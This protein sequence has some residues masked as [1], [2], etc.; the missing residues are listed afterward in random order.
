VTIRDDR[1]LAKA[2]AA[3]GSLYRAMVSL[4]SETESAAPHAFAVLAEGPLHEIRRIQTE[5]DEYTGVA[6]VQVEEAPLWLRL[7]GPRARWGETP[8]SVLT[9]FVDAFRKGVQAVAGYNATGRI[10]GRPPLDLQR[11]CDPEVVAFAP[12]S[13]QIG[14]R[15]PEP[16]QLALFTQ[17]VWLHARAGLIEFI[18]AADWAAASTS[19]LDELAARFT[20]M[21]KRRVVLRALKPFVP[22]PNGGVDFIE[23]SGSAVPDHRTIRLSQ[24]AAERI[25]HAFESAV[26]E[27]EERYE[28]EI[29]EMDLDR[30][31]FRL[32]NVPKVEEVACRFG[33]DLA[34]IA[35]GLLGKRVRVIG[36]RTFSTDAAIGPLEVV[37]LE[38]I[39]DST[40]PSGRT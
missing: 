34:P 28:G 6:R 14:L 39:E 5:I 40:P 22:R 17:G 37:D 25:S 24:D 33:D 18:A 32:R 3:L 12:G 31:T 23:L 2:Q 4:R 7:D 15:L 29:R 13:F 35:D 26:S 1:E 27:Q 10:A 9:A 38:R 36:T 30:Q 21:R 20:D 11:A 16:E 19:S 8:A